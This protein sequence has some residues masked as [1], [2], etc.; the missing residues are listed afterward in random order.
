MQIT[1]YPLKHLIMTNKLIAKI[2]ILNDNIS[3]RSDK[4]GYQRVIKYKSKKYC[5]LTIILN[6]LP[7]AS[8][9]H[10]LYTII[11]YKLTKICLK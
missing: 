11:K 2:L 8:L 4:E 1:K 6:I 10:L 5:R 9:I 7:F 3:N